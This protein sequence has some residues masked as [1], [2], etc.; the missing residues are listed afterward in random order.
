MN[1]SAHAVDGSNPPDTDR[2]ENGSSPY[3][4]DFSSQVLD[5]TLFHH[6][7]FIPLNPIR[8]RQSTFDRPSK[9]IRCE[10]FA[11]VLSAP[12]RL[13][14]F[15]YPV[16]AL[17]N[18]LRSLPL[19]TATFTV[20]AQSPSTLQWQPGPNLRSATLPLPA[21]GKPGFS[22]VS[23]STSGVTF[24]NQLAVQRVFS[25]HNLLNGS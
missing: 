21:P 13:I 9:S 4:V 6:R 22:L 25:N 14:D 2:Q 8:P 10:K 15:R 12:L 5:S 19:I 7:S 16:R 3:F 1:T 23:Q 20:G 11:L 17:A 24:T 18:I